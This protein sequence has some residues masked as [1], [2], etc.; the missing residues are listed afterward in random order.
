VSNVGEQA[1]RCAMRRICVTGQRLG[2]HM[3]KKEF[4]HMQGTE[5]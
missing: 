5:A 4:L 3:L 2:V 1:R